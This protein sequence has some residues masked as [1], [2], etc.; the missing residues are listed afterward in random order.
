[1][2]FYLEKINYENNIWKNAIYLT[3]I[4]L[5]LHLLYNLYCDNQSNQKKYNK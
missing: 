2:N 4:I 1:M 5:I 3:L